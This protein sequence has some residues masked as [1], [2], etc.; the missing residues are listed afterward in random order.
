MGSVSALAFR[1]LSKQVSAW[2]LPEGA[3]GNLEFFVE[4]LVG[5]IPTS[6]APIGLRTQLPC[7]PSACDNPTLCRRHRA[8]AHELPSGSN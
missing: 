8:G 7:P 5:R 2:T 3:R 6:P 1:E 4:R